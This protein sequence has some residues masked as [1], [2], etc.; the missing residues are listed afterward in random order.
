M[1]T[2]VEEAGEESQVSISKWHLEVR[3]GDNGASPFVMQM[4]D[5]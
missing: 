1:G 5:T 3:F 4:E 2:K